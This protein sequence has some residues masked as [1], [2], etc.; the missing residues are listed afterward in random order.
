LH[1]L[2]F[3]VS[4]SLILAVSVALVGKP[5]NTGQNNNILVRTSYVIVNSGMYQEKI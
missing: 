1:E 5:V 2:P 4:W 3:P